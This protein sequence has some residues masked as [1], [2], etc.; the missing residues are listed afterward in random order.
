MKICVIGTGYVGLTTGA[1]L[2]DLGHEIYCV[3]KNK[4][5]IEKLIK[6]D[7]PIYEPGLKELIV[8]NKKRRL[9]H[10]ST[11]IQSVI[12]ECPILYIT[13]G[14]PTNEDGSQNLTALNEVIDTLVQTITSHKTVI[15]KSTVLPGTNEWIHQTLIEKGIDSRLF[16][17]VSNPEFLREGNAVFDMMNPDKIVVGGKSPQSMKII[18]TLYEKLDAPF[19]LTSLTGAEMIKYAN[20]ALLATKISFMN[21]IARICDAYNV[22][23]TQ[24]AKALGTDTRIGPYF[25]NAGLGYGGS[26]FPKDIRALEY[27]AKQKNIDPEMLKAVQNINDSQIDLY[28]DKLT[29]KLTN[30]DGKKITVW[31]LAFKPDTDDIRESRSLLLIEKLLE[32]G[33][34]V[35]AYDPIVHSFEHAIT[36]HQDMYDA[37]KGADALIIA[38]EWNQFK[39]VD[40]KMV[41]DL[42]KGNIL[43]DGRNII[44]PKTVRNHQLQYI[45]VAR[46]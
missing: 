12:K 1:V 24:I 42:M 43:V 45:G 4:S 8:R 2:A 7:I 44:D 39:T 33:T 17:V 31:G 26:C 23:V 30:L 18:K 37:I 27:A 11:D 19:I 46:Q 32:R 28:I 13:V 15:I 41:H 14:T 38:T 20:N 5:K 34:E 9:L 29:N 3:D 22:E 16:D 6:G 40:W 10:F 35:H 21:E 36:I 25:L